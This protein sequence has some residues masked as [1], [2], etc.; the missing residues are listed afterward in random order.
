MTVRELEDILHACPDK[1]KDV[2]IQN[3]A[4]ENEGV[5]IDYVTI[6]NCGTVWIAGLWKDG[7]E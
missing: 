3:T 5:E 7:K 1:G 2:K 4:K 6:F